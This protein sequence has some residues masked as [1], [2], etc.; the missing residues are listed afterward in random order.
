MAEQMLVFSCIQMF[1]ILRSQNSNAE[2]P[3][4]FVSQDIK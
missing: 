2:Q 1:L 3:S 4:A